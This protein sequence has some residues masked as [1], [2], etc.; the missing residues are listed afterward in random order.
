MRVTVIASKY[1]PEP[2]PTWGRSI[3]LF[4]ESSRR[5]SQEVIPVTVGQ[6]FPEQVATL[7]QD[8]DW[9]QDFF[10]DVYML[11]KK[12]FHYISDRVGIFR[13]FT[14]RTNASSGHIC[15]CGARHHISPATTPRKLGDW[16]VSQ[17]L[18][19]HCL[20]NEKQISLKNS[21]QQSFNN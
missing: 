21:A 1:H 6:R 18:I 8:C 17:Y 19:L 13:T 11:Q 2:Q 10:A 7:S 3:Q 14:L 12:W 20:T 15:P 5:L 16:V 9:I 4:H